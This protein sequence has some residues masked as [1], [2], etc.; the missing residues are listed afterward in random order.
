M[1]RTHMHVEQALDAALSTTAA[2]GGGGT[3][4]WGDVGRDAFSYDRWQWMAEGAS[5]GVGGGLGGSPPPSREAGPGVGARDEAWEAVDAVTRPDAVSKVNAVNRSGGVSGAD[6]VNGPAKAA[7]SACGEDSEEGGSVD[8]HSADAGGR[9]RR[10][11]TQRR[12]A[13]GNGSKKARGGS[14]SD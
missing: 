13:A 5:G 9:S 11:P 12:P 1:I 6:A 4:A 3:G 14:S 7:S 2:A 10:S 8:R